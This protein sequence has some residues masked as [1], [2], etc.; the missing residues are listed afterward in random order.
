[1][2]WLLVCCA[3]EEARMAGRNEKVGD[4]IRSRDTEKRRDEYWDREM[5][6][7]Y[8][9]SRSGSR[10]SNDATTGVEWSGVV[11]RSLMRVDD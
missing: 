5:I 9:P 10:V 6:H 11:C 2:D 1:M 4:L 8:S 3:G 7:R